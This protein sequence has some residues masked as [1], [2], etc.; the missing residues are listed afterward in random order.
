[1]PNK[2]YLLHVSFS[3]VVLVRN[4]YQRRWNLR[5]PIKTHNSR[6]HIPWVVNSCL[7]WSSLSLYDP[8]I[9]THVLLNTRQYLWP[10][11]LVPRSAV[12]QMRLKR[13]SR[14][15]HNRQPCVKKNVSPKKAATITTPWWFPML[16]TCTCLSCSPFLSLLRLGQCLPLWLTP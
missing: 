2:T 15:T 9:L 6:F 12:W 3:P 4:G 10:S 1:M 14:R 5:S 16:S 13:S 8:C 7:F 11:C